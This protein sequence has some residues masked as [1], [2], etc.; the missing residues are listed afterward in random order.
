MVQCEVRGE[1]IIVGLKDG[2]IP[3][4]VGK[5]EGNLS[6]V[7]YKGLAK[8]VRK[9]A[10][11]A[12]AHWFGITGQTVTKW[13]RAMGVGPT[14]PGTSKLRSGYAQ[15]PWARRA[16]KKAQDKATDPERRRKISE[17]KIGKP[18][19]ASVHEALRKANTGSKRSEESSGKMSTAHR[20]RGTRPPKAGRPWSKKEDRGA[21]SLSMKGAAKVTGRTVKA[22]EM[23]RVV[24]R[25]LGRLK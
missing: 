19:P 2:K 18:R 16:I 17:S 14:T 24:L 3:W 7:V 4:P 21:L 25:K 12:V 8:A 23:R 15:E 5:R 9:E 6:L 22:V 11:Q 1:V 20:S 10:N 13:R